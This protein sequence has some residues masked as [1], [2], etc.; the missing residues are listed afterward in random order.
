MMSSFLERLVNFLLH[1][2]VFVIVVEVMAGDALNNDILFVA[3]FAWASIMT[4]L[5]EIREKLK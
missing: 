4:Q 5:D 2:L 1:A 3:T